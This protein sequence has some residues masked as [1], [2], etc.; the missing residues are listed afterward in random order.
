MARRRCSL[1]PA[2]R[3][4]VRGGGGSS[5]LGAH[6]DV[7]LAG[8]RDRPVRTG[9]GCGGVRWRDRL[10]ADFRPRGGADHRNVMGCWRRRWRPRAPSEQRSALLPRARGPA[11]CAG[12]TPRHARLRPQGAPPSDAIGRR[13]AGRGES[14][15]G[16]AGRRRDEPVWSS[17]L[18]RSRHSRAARRSPPPERGAGRR[19]A[20]P[21]SARPRSRK[22]WVRPAPASAGPGTDPR[23]RPTRPR[24]AAVPS[25]A[26]R[27][28]S[29]PHEA[30]AN[31]AAGA[32][33][34]SRLMCPLCLPRFLGRRYPTLADPPTPRFAD[35]VLLG[36]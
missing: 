16:P 7:P 8:A 31:L 10:G 27:R 21:L 19:D 30:R 4:S 12:R 35:D 29:D 5:G 36:R 14:P 9:W 20:C 24:R 1:G 23:S 18:G 11:S 25:R 6:C 17:T 32:R 26:G 34:C 33:R 22:G 3:Q 13:A 2:S 15:V 28:G